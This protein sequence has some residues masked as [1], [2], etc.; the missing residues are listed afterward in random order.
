MWNSR[1]ELW[2][3]QAIN[4]FVANLARGGQTDNVQPNI[5]PA[6]IHCQP[7]G[8]SRKLIAEIH[9]AEQ[10]ACQIIYMTVDHATTE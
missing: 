3:R 9:P 4:G 8:P 1:G 10:L 7:I 5:M 6:L 2:F